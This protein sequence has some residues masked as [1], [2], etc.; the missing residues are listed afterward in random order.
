MILGDPMIL[1]SKSDHPITGNPEGY[2]D[3]VLALPS[4]LC[5]KRTS[6]NAETRRTPFEVQYGYNCV[7]TIEIRS[8]S[9][10]YGRI[11][12]TVPICFLL[13]LGS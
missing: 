13:G 5:A 3:W 12:I 2:G 8:G 9:Q 6:V 4:V 11:L 10:H 1:A 7:L